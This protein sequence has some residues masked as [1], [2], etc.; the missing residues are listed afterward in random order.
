MVHFR[1]GIADIPEIC[2]QAGV[3]HSVISPGSRNVP[4]IKSFY[5]H[6]QI[7]LHSALDERVASYMA[8][9]MSLQTGLP[10][11]ILCTSGTAVLNY[12]PAIAEAFY[13]NIPLVVLTADR[14]PEWIDQ[15]D[16]QSIRQQ[17]VFENHV[18]LSVQLPVET[19]DEAD[20]LEFRK[21]FSEAI[22]EAIN[23]NKPVHINIPLR[24][25]V[26]D[27]IPDFSSKKITFPS[28]SFEAKQ[29]KFTELI[30][31]WNQSKRKIIVC[32]FS[33]PNLSLNELLVK[34]AC[35]PTVVIMAENLSNQYNINYFVSH[36]RLIHAIDEDVEMVP[37][38]VLH[39]GEQV[40]SK[41][42][43]M[44]LRSKETKHKWSV[45]QYETTADP[46]ASESLKISCKPEVF[47]TDLLHSSKSTNSN[48]SE[49]WKKV[50]KKA[51]IHF[52]AYLEK[53]SFA[54]LIAIKTILENLPEDSVLH[55]GNSTVVRYSQLFTTRSDITYY[56]NRGTSGIDGCI[57][58]SAGFSSIDKRINTLILGDVSFLYDSN[59]LFL[60]QKI[61]NFRVIVI[62]NNG[63]DIFR[64]IEKD[65]H[66]VGFEELL[67]TPIQCYIKKLVEASRLHYFYANNEADLNGILTHFFEQS[68]TAKVLEIDTSK[69]NNAQ[70]FKEIFK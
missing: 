20:Y 23:R 12:A 64:V 13:Q 6:K 37:D 62:S 21:Q 59:A 45:S 27:V 4:I 50:K 24:E 63:G 9:G 49:L 14:P 68:I 43:K 2:F 44:W 65:N 66:N 8:L 16:G 1:Q 28:N 67:T 5:Q 35:D 41:R 53:T 26:Y 54:D 36:D 56:S 42:L 17:N 55:L 39:I 32:G 40:L 58:T 38:L 70:V 15:G 22:Q 3:K 57:S 46:Y 51:Q 33:R 34:L 10:T 47:L 19:N 11:V 7:T 60:L 52:E 48:Y 69:C 29:E 18:C 31:T 30:T 25:P 61:P